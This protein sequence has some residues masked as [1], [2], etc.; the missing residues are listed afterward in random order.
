MALE[1]HSGSCVSQE[2][3]S[4][5]WISHSLATH[6]SFTWKDISPVW[7]HHKQ[8]CHDPSHTGFCV[9]IVFISLG[10]IPRTE[11]PRFYGK[12]YV[13]FLQKT[14]CFPECA[15]Y[16][17]SQYGRQVL[18]GEACYLGEI[19]RGAYGHYGINNFYAHSTFQVQAKCPP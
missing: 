9:N 2:L 4:E 19:R 12:Q 17:P 8:S 14:A 11:V 3:F 15:F 13:R 16:I 10:Y 1:T 18:L 6:L 7:G 5:V